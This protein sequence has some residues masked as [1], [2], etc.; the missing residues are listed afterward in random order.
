MSTSDGGGATAHLPE[1]VVVEWEG[2]HRFRGGRESRPSVL[3][4]GSK[5]A[6]PGAVDAVAIALATCSAIDVVDILEKRRTPAESLTIEVSYARVDGTPRR[7]SA[8]HLAFRVRT[9]SEL[10]HV[11]RAVS[12]SVEKYCSVA[13]SLSSDIGITSEVVLEAP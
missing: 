3:L 7:I 9:A 4:D 2:E 10:P 1:R 12:L 5:V 6:G 11:E 8:L 13:S